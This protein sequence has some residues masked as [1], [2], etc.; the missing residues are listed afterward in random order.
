MKEIRSAYKDGTIVAVKPQE[1]NCDQTS[2]FDRIFRDYAGKDS[3]SLSRLTHGELSWKNSRVGIPEE[4]NSDNPMNTNDIRK[5]ADR[6]KTRRNML[7][8][9]GLA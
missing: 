7:I 8:E 9:L 6:I 2:L 4:A 1:F 5:D 3:W